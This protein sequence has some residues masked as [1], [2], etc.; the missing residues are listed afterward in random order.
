MSPV[1]VAGRFALT[2]FNSTL[3]N[4]NAKSSLAARYMK[5]TESSF[6]LTPTSDQLKLYA[7][8]VEYTIDQ[9]RKQLGY[10][11][12]VGVSQGLEFGAAWLR[13]HDLLF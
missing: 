6:K 12:Q 3:M 2:R 9:A 1:R 8:D 4:L 5:V 13:Q 10:A 7:L 11:P